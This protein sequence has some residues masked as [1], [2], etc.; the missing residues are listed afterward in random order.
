MT[1]DRWGLGIKYIKENRINKIKVEKAVNQYKKL[2]K[3]SLFTWRE[4]LYL[5]FK[6]VKI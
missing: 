3:R 5:W 2:I 4:R 1:E 6:G